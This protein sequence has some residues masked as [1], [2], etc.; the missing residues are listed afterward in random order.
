[1]QPASGLAESVPYKPVKPDSLYLTPDEVAQR[2]R[3]RRTIEFSAFDAPE[4]SGRVVR[5][6]GAHAGHRFTEERA[7]PSAN[8]FDHVVRHVADRRAA[9]RKV[10]L[11][12]WSEG[13]LDRLVQILDEHGLG[14]LTRV[15]TLQEAESLPSGQ[16]GL[17]V[18]PLET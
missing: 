9:G 2:A 17:A 18:L 1:R 7:D 6:A 5:H 11:A 12:G 15:A 8:V 4:T 13:S 10:L 16:V 3:D 14:G